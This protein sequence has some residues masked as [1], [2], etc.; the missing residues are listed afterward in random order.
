MQLQVL[1]ILYLLFTTKGT[2]EY[3]YT[4]DLCV[5]VD[6]FLRE[7]VDLD[8]ESDSVCISTIAY[9]LFVTMGLRTAS[10]CL[11]TR[12]SPFAHE[13]A[14]S[15]LAVQA[16]ANSTSSRIS[17]SGHVHSRHQSYHEASRRAMPERRMVCAI[18]EC[19]T[20]T[21]GRFAG[22]QSV[23]RQHHLVHPCTGQLPRFHRAIDDDSHPSRAID[24]HQ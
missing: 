16:T 24:V 19:Q 5:L 8:E 6:V 22:V 21:A 10:T 4:N 1:K 11:P 14:T 15:F 3:F 20:R 13:N 18:Q 12:P 2:S 7:L 17:H 9:T 23:L